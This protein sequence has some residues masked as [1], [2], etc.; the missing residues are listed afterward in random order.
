[1]RPLTCG[2]TSIEYDVQSPE[3]LSCNTVA[4]VARELVKHLL[5]MRN[6]APALIDDLAA[7]VAAI[8]L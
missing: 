4:H 6:Q 8:C 5:F 7:K 3:P 1:M 2:V